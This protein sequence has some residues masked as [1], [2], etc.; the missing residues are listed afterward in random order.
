MTRPALTAALLRAADETCCPDLERLLR[1]AAAV[2][3]GECVCG[4]GR[5]AEIGGLARPCYQRA[6]RS[7]GAPC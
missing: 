3:S 4:C 2:V 1:A 7:G 6:R 5:R